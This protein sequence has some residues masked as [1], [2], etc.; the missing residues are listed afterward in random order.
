V[1]VGGRRPDTDY[2]AASGAELNL[3]NTMTW[4]GGSFGYDRGVKLLP[5]LVIAVALLAGCGGGGGGGDTPDPVTLQVAPNAATVVAGEAQQF[6]AAVQNA[7]NT[8][9]TWSVVEA[10]G[11][12]V[13][14]AGLYTAPETVGTYTVR[15]TSVADATKSATATVTVTARPTLRE[16]L[17]EDD[18][19]SIDVSGVT[20]IR[21]SE[22]ILL[23]GQGSV[24]IQDENVVLSYFVDL[25]W[26][27]I[28]IVAG[29]TE[30]IRFQLDGTTYT[31][32][33][34]SIGWNPVADGT[35]FG[36]FLNGG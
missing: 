3:A 2:V 20:I 28:G 4:A 35:F 31:E 25:P 24:R 22:E 18:N 32:D 33:L 30:R 14:A 27:N 21:E 1:S 26:R 36:G 11:G 17:E 15:A 23:Q 7:E 16:V 10:G 6:T 9:V 29:S 34:S 13:T 8:T 12:T 5:S 19:E